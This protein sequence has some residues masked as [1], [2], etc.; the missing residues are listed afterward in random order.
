M[1]KLVRV[2]AFFASFAL[3]SVINSAPVVFSAHV[4]REAPALAPMIAPAV[5]PARV[6]REAPA[7]APMIAPAVAPARVKREALALAPKIGRAHV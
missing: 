2:S 1:Q 6:E 4:V 3:L 5:V 7:L